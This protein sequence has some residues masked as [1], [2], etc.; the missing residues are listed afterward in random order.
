MFVSSLYRI[1]FGNPSKWT[2]LI[3][4][5]LCNLSSLS[6]SCPSWKLWLFK[7][8]LDVLREALLFSSELILGFDT[9]SV[10][11]E[12]NLKVNYNSFINPINAAD[13]IDVMNNIWNFYMHYWLIEHDY[14]NNLNNYFN[15][16][17][18]YAKYI[19]SVRK[20]CLISHRFSA[21]Y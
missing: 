18:K 3:V 19:Q 7:E 20:K 8:L 1:K 15:F 4:V 14:K 16:L 13:F 9:T 2:W 21:D 5:C 6:S 10:W 12:W 11:R 17:Q